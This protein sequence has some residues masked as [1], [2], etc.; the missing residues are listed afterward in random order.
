MGVNQIPA[1]I[2]L[3]LF[4][5]QAG[6]AFVLGI[7]A[8]GLQAWALID[9]A[10]TRPDAFVAAGKRTKGFW[11]AVTGVAAAIG[12]VFLASPFNIF[13]LL[14]IIAAAVYLTD[15][16][17][18]VKSLRGGNNNRGTHMGPYGPW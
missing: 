16:R 10:I 5:A 15:V 18:A 13:S 12:F 3:N 17:P 7:L 1:Q 2:D 11:I 14:A 9:A 4:S 6:V 8:A